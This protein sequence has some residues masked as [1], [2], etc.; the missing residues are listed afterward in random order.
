MLDLNDQKR[1]ILQ[2]ISAEKDLGAII[3]HKLK[4]SSHIVTEVKKENKMVGLISESH[5]HSV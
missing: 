2:F 1:K 5:K 3:D 4:F